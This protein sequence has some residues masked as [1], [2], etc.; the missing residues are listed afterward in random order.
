MQT[1]NITYN[2]QYTVDF[3]HQQYVYLGCVHLGC[4]YLGCVHVGCLL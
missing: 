3:E 4:L 1:V 2:R